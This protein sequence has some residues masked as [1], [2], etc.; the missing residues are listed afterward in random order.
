MSWVDAAV[1]AWASIGRRFGRTVLTIFSVAL[2]TALLIAMLAIAGTARTRVLGQLTR[3]GPLAGI[4][5]FAAAPNFA[6]LQSDDPPLGSPRAIDQSALRR[7]AALPGVTSVLPVVSVPE[8]IL[9]PVGLDRPGLDVGRPFTD[10]LV[11]VDLAHT[12]DLPISVIA[13]RLPTPGSLREVSVSQAFLSRMH[14]TSAQANRVIG[15]SL[16]VAAPR[17]FPTIGAEPD[18]GLWI[19]PEIVGV[20]SQDAGT[21]A[22]LGSLQLAKQQLGFAAA[23][24]DPGGAL[25]VSA[26]TYSGALV[27]ARSLTDIA[28]VRRQIAE[29]GYATSAP[30]NLIQS[31]LRYLHVVEIVLSGIGLIALFIASLGIAGALLAAVRERRREIGVLKAIGARDRDVLRV[32]L[33]EAALIGVIGGTAGAIAGTGMALTL[34]ATVNRYLTTQGL[35]GV[36]T[37]IPLLLLVGGVLGAVVLALIAGVVPAL[38][39]AKLPAREAV[40]EG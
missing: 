39:A 32:F 23:G 1:L 33:V 24:P 28:P 15:T 8:F 21:G 30:E 9:P 34:G 20:V 17:V 25:H 27:I 4:R 22:L 36:R 3:G 13:G 38:R 40:A 6:D 16:E 31:V 5:V 2:A 37:S 18:R 10:A 29:I 19:K 26:S 12:Q 14:L 35:A 11:G 7:I